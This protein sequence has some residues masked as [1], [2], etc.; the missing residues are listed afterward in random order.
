[1][2]VRELTAIADRGYFKG[3]EIL[4]CE[5]TGVTPLVPKPLTGV[6]ERYELGDFKGNAP[7]VRGAVVDLKG[8]K[9]PGV[10]GADVRG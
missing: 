7:F 10:I 5:A 1:M 3:E 8:P 2:G 9:V 6:E 4:A